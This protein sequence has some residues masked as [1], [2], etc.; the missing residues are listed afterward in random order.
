MPVNVTID[1]I[2]EAWRAYAE[3]TDCPHKL[4]AHRQAY[5]DG[6]HA[7]T[8]RRET[9]A[10]GKPK[11]NRVTNWIA[12]GCDAY[13]GALTGTPYQVSDAE[14]ANRD[15]L[16][17]DAPSQNE[18][19]DLYSEIAER[20][21]L[22][23]QDQENLLTAMV[24]G[25]G[26]ELHA[27]Y[28]GE[29]VIT[30]D[31]PQNWAFIKNDTGE[32][33]VGIKRI[34]LKKGTL[35]NG[36]ILGRDIEWMSVYDDSTITDYTCPAGGGGM[37]GAWVAMGEGRKHFYG[38]LPIVVWSVNDSQESI[39]ADDVIGQHDE[40]ND[41]DSAS[42]DDIRAGV[43]NVLVLN[44]VSQDFIAKHERTIR[45][46]RIIPLEDKNEQDAKYLERNINSD[47]VE[48]RLMRTREAIH[49]MLRV[50][51]VMHIVGATGATS[52]IALK[53]KFTPLIQ[54]AQSMI[55][56]LKKHVKERIE[57]INAMLGPS[58]QKQIADY[59][60]NINIS[61]PMNTIDQ[62]AAIGALKGIVSHKTMLEFLEGVDDPERELARI[63]AESAMRGISATPEEQ[64]QGV[65]A[66]AGAAQQALMPKAAE[67]L[68]LIR[69]IV[70]QAARDSGAIDAAI[71][72]AQR[73][74]SNGAV[75]NA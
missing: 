30:N 22:D 7:I 15:P 27:F 31:D 26:I 34:T 45:E 9:Y 4:M 56:Y 54:R 32:N 70:L 33:V 35:F 62:W 60:V 17:G 63:Q 52:G 50:P 46:K 71:S 6:R 28:D 42:G 13:V 73:Q 3:G 37:G 49:T 69:T 8:E 47:P 2:N 20:N 66:G 51:D 48:K 5:Y 38:R 10:D 75:T 21:N 65:E 43:D 55:H 53:L 58:S 23:A 36:E 29:I 16:P 1:Q 59:V 12:Y 40:Y 57:L 19:P 44:G 39:I 72:G 64:A 24:K 18:G 25:Y 61:L 68:D 67:V 74:Q 11:S 14:R 41:I